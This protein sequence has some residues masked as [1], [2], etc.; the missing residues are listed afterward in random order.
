MKH[1]IQSIRLFLSV[2]VLFCTTI[3]LNAQSVKTL[4][5]IIPNTE[6]VLSESERSRYASISEE[7]IMEKELIDISRFSQ[8]LTESTLL[9]PLNGKNTQ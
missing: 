8:V 3:N 4:F 6:R 7:L 5:D 9:V 2:L 1:N